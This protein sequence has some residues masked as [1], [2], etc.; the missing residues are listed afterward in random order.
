MCFVVTSKQLFVHRQKELHQLRQ[1]LLLLKH[2]AH[3]H[4]VEHS[5]RLG[6]MLYEDGVATPAPGTGMNSTLQQAATVS[7]AAEPLHEADDSKPVEGIRD[8]DSKNQL[9]KTSHRPRH[10]PQHHAQQT[11]P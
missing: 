5:S 7:E 1:H 11:A 6:M 8:V 3:E 2:A 9:P 4:G 10:H